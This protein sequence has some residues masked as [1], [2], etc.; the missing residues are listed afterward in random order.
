MRYNIV[1]QSN[2]FVMTKSSLTK[3]T[4]QQVA[5]QILQTNHSV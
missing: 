4:P 1:Q 5:S 2:F 3:Q